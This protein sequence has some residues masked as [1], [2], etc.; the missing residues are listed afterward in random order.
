MYHLCFQFIDLPH[1]KVGF[2]VL[3]NKSILH[4]PHITNFTYIC[5]I[6]HYLQL[7]RIYVKIEICVQAGLRFMTNPVKIRDLS[8]TFNI[9]NS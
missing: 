2:F 8:K 3:C 9:A 1:V 6:T 4:V 7:S 5:K